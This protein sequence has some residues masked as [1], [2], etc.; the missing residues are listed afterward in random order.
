MALPA[1]LAINVPILVGQF[2][3]DTACLTRG[4]N[5]T[6]IITFRLYGP[7]DPGSDLTGPY[8]ESVRTV[9]GNGSYTSE[10]VLIEQPGSYSW[11]VVY[12][13]DANNERVEE[14]FGP[15]ECSDETL[16]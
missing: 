6:G 3:Q 15:F 2:V 13:G 9:D 5:P 16:P 8:V 7:H 1:L 12:E 10:P 11:F 4:D 14:E